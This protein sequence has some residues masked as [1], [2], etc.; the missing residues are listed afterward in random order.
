MKR[1]LFNDIDAVNAPFRR[2]L[3]SAFHK[4]L[5]SG[6]FVLAE[7]VSQFEKQFAAYC[8]TGFCIG[9]GNGYDALVLAI[10]AFGFAPGAEIIVPANTYIATLL[11]VSANGLKPVLVEPDE[12]TF[13]INPAAIRSAITANTKA[14]LVVHLYGRVCPMDEINAIAGKH[15]LKIIE[16]CAQAHGA[17]YKGKRVGS[18]GH[19]AAFSFY[20]TKNLGALG[21]G[22]AVTTSGEELAQKIKALRNYGSLKRYENVVKGVNSRLDELQAAFLSVKLPHLDTINERRRAIAEKYLACI[23]NPLVVLPAAPVTSSEH[24]WHLFVIKVARR[25]KL[26]EYL[27]ANGIETAV[28]YPVPP[29]KQQAYEELNNLKLPVTETIHNMAL[30]LPLHAAMSDSDSDYIISLINKFKL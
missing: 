25:A 26:Q 18:F 7:N 15:G 29:H 22:G 8:D 28:H 5:Q 4:V 30:S 11:A 3:S 14:I 23:S 6:N 2:D 13:N 12:N 1:I 24:V 19:A 27:A 16:D 21:D 20:P 9:V 10:R 17:M